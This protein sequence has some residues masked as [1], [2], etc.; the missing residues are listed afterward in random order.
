MTNPIYRCFIC[1]N[2]YKS[3]KEKTDKLKE[4]MG[5]HSMSKK[6]R[7]KYTPEFNNEGNPIV[8]Y[9]N[10][11]GNH[12]YPKWSTLINY[13]SKYESGILPFQGGYM[14]QPAKFVEVMQL[15]HNLIR[16]NEQIIERKNDLLRKRTNGR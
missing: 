8:N 9:F 1:K 5:C 3:D 10:C 6:T 15:V 4:S 2:K 13:Y 16:E 12:Y 11:V 7:H 14:E